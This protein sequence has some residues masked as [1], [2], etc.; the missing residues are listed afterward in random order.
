MFFTRSEE[1]SQARFVPLI[2]DGMVDLGG[3]PTRPEVVARATELGRFT[4]EELAVPSHTRQDRETGRGAVE[5]RSHYAIWDARR[6]GVLLS[7]NTDRKQVLTDQGRVLRAQGRHALVVAQLLAAIV[8]AGVLHA[9][10]ERRV[11][12]ADLALMELRAHRDDPRVCLGG[13]AAALVLGEARA[14]GAEAKRLDDLR[15]AIEVVD[16]QLL[17]ELVG[18]LEVA[19]VSGGDEAAQQQIIRFAGHP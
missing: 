13:G 2:V 5:G 3:T 7:G 15:H 18:R 19:S 8:L 16:C 17:P 10:G 12:L 4:P 11:E 1:L 9:G 14:A 6:K